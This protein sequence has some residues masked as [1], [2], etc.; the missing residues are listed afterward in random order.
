MRLRHHVL[1]VLAVALL[2]LPA[3][4]Q[5]KRGPGK[6]TPPRMEAQCEG[7]QG[8]HLEACRVLGSYL[9]RWK[10]QKWAEV[11][12]LIHPKTL[13]KIAVAKKNIGE[14]RHAMAPW[15]WAKE[16]YLLH[17]WKIESIKDRYGGTV[18]INTVETTYRVEEDGFE[19]GGAASY[20]LGK[21]DGRWYVVERRSGGGGFNE[22]SIRL[23]MK[24]YFD[25]VPAKA[26]K[27][28]PEPG[29]ES[30]SDLD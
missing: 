20:L 16:V 5:K 12:K 25:P 28:A 11:R 10:E 17:D 24:D 7:R 21:K 14:E 26:E 3:A 6:P 23:G 19:E 13:E 29:S 1:W 9:D 2:A 22:D 15:Y 4:A 30:E 27:K 18:E 8:D